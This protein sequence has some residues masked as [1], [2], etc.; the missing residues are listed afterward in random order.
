[1]EQL[2]DANV[3]RRWTD[4]REWEVGRWTCCGRASQSKVT[5]KQLSRCVVRSTKIDVHLV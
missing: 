3:T 2:V 5:R 4:R 1:M